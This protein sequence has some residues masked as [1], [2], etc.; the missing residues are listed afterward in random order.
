M[1]FYFLS[2]YIKTE[3]ALELQMSAVNERRRRE[4]VARQVFYIL[5]FHFTKSQSECVSQSLGQHVFDL[6]IVIIHR[7][8]NNNNNIITQPPQSD[9][10]TRRAITAAEPEWCG[11][12]RVQ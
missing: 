1:G 10:S 9:A 11:L 6:I 5:L 2:Q 7:L 8:N 12:R 4:N 3:R